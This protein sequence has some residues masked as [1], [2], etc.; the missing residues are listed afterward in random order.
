MSQLVVT[1]GRHLVASFPLMP[2]KSPLSDD[3]YY[4]TGH[5]R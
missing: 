5:G 3:A 1:T 4:R 2:L